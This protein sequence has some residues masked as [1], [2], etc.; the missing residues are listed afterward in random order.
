[1]VFAFYSTCSFLTFLSLIFT[2]HIYPKYSENFNNYRTCSNDWTNPYV[3]S[4]PMKFYDIIRNQVLCNKYLSLFTWPFKSEVQRE[5]KRCISVC[6]AM[7]FPEFSW[8][9]FK[10]PEFLNAL[11]VFGNNFFPISEKIHVIAFSSYIAEISTQNTMFLLPDY[12]SYITKIGLFKCT[13]NFTT[14][15]WK[16]SDKNFWY[17]SYSFS[18]HRLWVLVRTASAS[19]TIYVFEQK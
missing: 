3:I 4:Y 11:Q 12:V 15:K 18:K 2:Y 5:R 13:E 9:Y 8:F 10:N 1:M 6:K 16:F 17:F 14:K 7:N 19:T